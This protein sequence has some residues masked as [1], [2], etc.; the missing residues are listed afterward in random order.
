MLHA[1]IYCQHNIPV[2]HVTFRYVT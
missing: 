2:C 1:V